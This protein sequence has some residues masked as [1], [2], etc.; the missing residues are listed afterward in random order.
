[1][2]ASCGRTRRVGHRYVVDCAGRSG[3]GGCCGLSSSPGRLVL[4]RLRRVGGESRF[5]LRWRHSADQEPARN[6]QS[7]AHRATAVSE[8]ARSANSILRRAHRVRRG[9]ASA[10]EKDLHQI[11]FAGAWQRV[12]GIVFD[13]RE[14]VVRTVRDVQRADYCCEGGRAGVDQPAGHSTV[15]L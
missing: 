12:C 2:C 1:M 3:L 8:R 15:Q 5:S 6:G 10:T 9:G 4:R 11:S 14:A 13:G 7:I